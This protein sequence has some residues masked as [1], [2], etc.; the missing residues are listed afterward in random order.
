MM[1]PMP[2]YCPQCGRKVIVYD[3]RASINPV[4]KCKKCKKMVVYD[5]ERQKTILRDVPKRDQASGMRFY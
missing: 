1:K 4:A 3:G 2:I 5:L